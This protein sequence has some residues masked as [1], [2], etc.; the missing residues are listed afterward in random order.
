MSLSP[1]QCRAARGWVDWSQTELA[2]RAGVHVNVVSR[3]ERGITRLRGNNLK[4]IVAAF[5]GSGVLVTGDGIR[6][7]QGDGRIP[8][9]S[10]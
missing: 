8:L 4:S 3:F 1:E 7:S 10:I 6:L 9:D 5:E 2:R